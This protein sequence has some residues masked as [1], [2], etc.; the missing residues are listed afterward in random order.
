MDT[1]RR[2]IHSLNK[3]PKLRSTVQDVDKIIE[4]LEAARAQV[5]AT[6]DT[7]TASLTMAKLQNPL[8]R[9][10]EVMTQD[11]KN[12]SKVHKNLGKTL[13]KAMPVKPLPTDH[14]V[15]AEH[16]DL[17]NRAIA[18]HLLREGEF[19][20]AETFQNET[21]DDVTLAD[22]TAT[23]PSTG[24]DGTEDQIM[25]EPDGG[26]PD[27][28]EMSYQ[29]EPVAKRQ[30]SQ[31]SH[32]PPPELKDRFADMY[33]ILE[34]IRHHDLGPA[35]EWAREHSEELEARG[36]NFEFDLTK[37]QYVWLF[38]GPEVNGLPSDRP[39]G[40]LGAYL[41]GKENFPRFQ[42]RHLHEIQQLASAM[43]FA[44]NLPDSPYSSLFAVDQS[45]S[46]IAASFTREFCSLLGLSAESPLYIATTAG[47]L[48]LPRAIKYASAALAKGTAWTTT[49]E[50]AFETPLPSNMIY[51]SIFVC[52]VSKEQT[53]E[54]NPPV[55][56]PCGHVLGR[57]TLKKLCKGNRFKCPYC[58]Q[59]GLFKDARRIVL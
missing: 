26:G 22:V 24:P 56:I 5:A 46:E 13:D 6:L 38:R 45:F 31:A 16:M 10:F 55:M 59:D 57:E 19:S 17:I 40:R 51:H 32:I 47:A 20:V 27:L 9:H 43:V 53:N 33:R 2:E 35:I 28:M 36:S 50:L 42:A 18:M 48:A 21:Q 30:Q 1:L 23:Q 39:N 49:D 58:P 44:P 41:Y 12:V 3:A 34:S 37:L 15:M 14:D 4:E 29:S 52:P 8:N 7:H 54:A 11:L 25:S